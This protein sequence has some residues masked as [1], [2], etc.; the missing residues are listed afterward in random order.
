MPNN[1]K[2]FNDDLPGPELSFCKQLVFRRTVFA[3][4]GY[5]IFTEEV[6]KFPTEPLLSCP[7]AATK[8]RVTYG[9][10]LQFLR[11]PSM[12][13]ADYL[14]GDNLKAFTEMDVILRS[15]WDA[16]DDDW[17]L[18]GIDQRVTVSLT[19][20]DAG[21]YVPCLHVD[22]KDGWGHKQFAPIVEKYKSVVAKIDIG[23]A[24]AAYPQQEVVFQPH[25]TSKKLEPGVSISHGRYRSGTV[26]CIVEVMEDGTPE[27]CLVTAAHVVSLNN[28]SKMGDLIYSPGKGSVKRL[29]TEHRVGK[30]TGKSTELY[31]VASLGE[32]NSAEDIAVDIDVALVKIT[33]A[34]LTRAPMR[35]F[36]P[37]PT[38]TSGV[39]HIS[40]SVDEAD[41]ASYLLEEVNL[42]GAVSGHQKGTLTNIFMDRRVIKLPNQLNYIYK[43]LLAVTPY[44]E[45]PY[46]KPGDS[47]SIIYSNDG[48]L[49]GFLIGADRY[50]SYACLGDRCIKEFDARIV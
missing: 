36:V 25:A 17:H 30:L 3:E 50:A 8:N 37:D 15:I 33:D 21:K 45:I 7:F 28:G 19:K 6:K 4:T 32:E 48:K 41:I 1:R 47:G 2:S 27:L 39:I 44:G 49:V 35:T 10:I 20:N 31:P 9:S 46:S 38:A 18:P 29:L 34:G 26:G 22:K 16:N 24:Q 5:T 42:F 12:G 23:E 11:D 40:E 13:I 43:E 14:S